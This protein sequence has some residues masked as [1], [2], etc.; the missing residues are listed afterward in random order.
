MLPKGKAAAKARDVKDDDV[1]EAKGKAAAAPSVDVQLLDVPPP[2][3]APV[4]L[5]L[6][7]SMWGPG[8]GLELSC[9]ARPMCP[10]ALPPAVLA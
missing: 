2:P 9:E 8:E 4:C 5:P 6:P 7:D 1:W 3:P 10:G